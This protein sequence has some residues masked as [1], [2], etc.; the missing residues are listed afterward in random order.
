MGGLL[1]H[2]QTVFEITY[3]NP[4]VELDPR[5][6][7]PKDY[8]VLLQPEFFYLVMSFGSCLILVL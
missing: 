4:K 6:Y 3:G 5:P 8:H 1:L 2:I 7:L